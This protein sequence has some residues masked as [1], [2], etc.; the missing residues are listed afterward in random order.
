M[1]IK[2]RDLRAAGVCPKAREWA[3]KN[4]FDWRDFVKNGIDAEKLIAV[5]D[6]QALRVVEVARG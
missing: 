1:I 6:A 4:G 2:M 3:H 5:G